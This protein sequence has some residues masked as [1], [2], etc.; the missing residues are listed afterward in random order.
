MLSDRSIL[1]TICV[2]LTNAVGSGIC[3]ALEAVGVWEYAVIR[4]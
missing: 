2:V 3:G 4:W 1:T